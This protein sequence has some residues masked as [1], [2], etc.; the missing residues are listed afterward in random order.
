MVIRLS[1]T[2]QVLARRVCL[3]EQDVELHHFEEF[4]PY[5]YLSSGFLWAHIKKFVKF[6]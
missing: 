6:I 2:Q 4:F 3:F 1:I 5:F